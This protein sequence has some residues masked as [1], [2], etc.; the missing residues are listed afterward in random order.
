MERTKLER[1]K[2]LTII[3]LTSLIAYMVIT[4]FTHEQERD[5]K[6]IVIVPS[7]AG[8]DFTVKTENELKELLAQGYDVQVVY[9]L[10]INGIDL[11]TFLLT[12]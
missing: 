9:S 6:A 7:L 8:E 2:T 11:T 12:K 1:A 10:D 4:G 5:V 3:V